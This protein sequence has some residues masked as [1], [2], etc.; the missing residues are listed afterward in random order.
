MTEVTSEIRVFMRH[1]RAAKLCSR[2]TRDWFAK[3]DL[4]YNDF[5]TNGIPVSKLE[6]TGDALA[7]RAVVA[8]KREAGINGR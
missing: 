6:E 4:D 5:L 7:A 1:V 3:Y 2:G 8:A